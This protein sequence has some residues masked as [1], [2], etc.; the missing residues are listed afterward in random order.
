MVYYFF[1][2]VVNFPHGINISQLQKEIGA[3]SAIHSTCTRI[4]V[5]SDTVTIWFASALDAGETTALNATV[6]AHVPQPV[7]VN[8]MPF[9]LSGT[10]LLKAEI[11][12]VETHYIGD[13]TNEIH[14]SKQPQAHYST[15]QAAIAANPG[16]DIVFVVHPGVYVEAN[17]IV[18]EPGCVLEAEGSA[19]NTFIVAADPTRAVLSITARSRVEGLT[20]TGGSTGIYFDGSSGQGLYSAIMECFLINCL[21]GIEIDAKNVQNL[22]GI[23]DTLYAR[24][25]IVAPTTRPLDKGVYIHSGGQFISVSVSVYGIPPAP[26]STPAIPITYAYYCTDPVSKIAMSL[27]NCY[28]T[29][30]GLYIDNDCNSEIALLTARYNYNGIVIGPNGTGQTRL[31]VSS[32]ES[33]LSSHYDFAVYAQNAI[34]EVHSGVMDD[35][36]IY[37]PYQVALNMHYHTSSNGQSRQHLTGVICVGTPNASSELYIGEGYYDIYDNIVLQNTSS[38]ETGT[39]T[40][41]TVYS[42][43]TMTMPFNLFI[44]TAAD[45]C[46]YIGRNEVPVGIHVSVTIPTSSLTEEEVI[47]WAYW[48]GTSWVIFNAMQTQNAAPY[49][50]CEDSFISAVG[51]YQVRFGLTSQS[52]AAL[53]TINGVS[54]KWVRVRVVSNLS[55]IPQSSFIYSH[56]NATK[57]NKD[58]FVEFFGDARPIKTFNWDINDMKPCKTIGNQTVYLGKSLGA[59]LQNN[60]FAANTLASIA[61]TCF[62]PTDLDGSFP[63]KLKF[64]IVGDSAT[65]G[66]VQFVV[67]YNFSNVGSS[68]YF[69]Q[70]DAPD[71]SADEMTNTAI[72]AM[73]AANTKYRGELQLDLAGINTNPSNT[74]PQLMWVSIQR[75]ATNANTSDTYPG[76]VALIQLTPY[77]ISWIDGCHLLAF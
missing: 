74:G 72:I 53:K 5:C 22:G 18:L 52:P 63:I 16:T 33:S 64:S 2:L 42:N 14:I 23:P 4:T 11:N 62:I 43:Q 49:Y 50:Y 58:G 36:K 60:L 71:T 32:L 21:V 6:S 38:A 12:G 66:N 37:N 47:E 25:M 19:E 15:I 34:V 24:E 10:N 76:N 67:R 8:I 41:V 7:D 54:K 48:N 69:Q 13:Q 77:Y 75:D 65:A 73:G 29:G 26:P 59:Q 39:F 56:T 57:Y 70:A 55:S 46:I 3:A 45:N 68:V 1:S 40:D 31:S 61:R 27:S 35:T 44:G 30:N 28:F 9:V 20:F 17:P 51:Q